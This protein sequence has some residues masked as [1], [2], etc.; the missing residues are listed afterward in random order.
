MSEFKKRKYE[1]NYES[2]E[3]DYEK[4][5]KDKINKIFTTKKLIKNENDKSSNYQ[6]EDF[7]TE[8]FG[9]ISE[10]EDELDVYL[11]YDKIYKDLIESIIQNNLGMKNRCTD[12]NVDMGLSNPR[13]L[14]GKTYCSNNE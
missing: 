2:E 3:S 1:Y 10:V 9:I 8:F 7:K 13:Q 5:E 11:D 6:E 12:C 4:E 14:C